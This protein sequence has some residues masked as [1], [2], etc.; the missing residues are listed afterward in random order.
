[1]HSGQLNPDG[2]PKYTNHLAAETSPYLR[3][4]THNPVQWYPWGSEALERARREQRPIH[5]SVGYNACHW[6]S[7]LEEESFEDEATAHILNDNFVNIKSIA[8][9]GP[10]SIASTR[11]RSRC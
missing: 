2:T 3:K 1:M 5:L 4:H 11:S 7:V 8:R 10:T 9:S 6:C